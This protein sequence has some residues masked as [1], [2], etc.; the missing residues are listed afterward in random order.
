MHFSPVIIYNVLF[1]S[2]RQAQ[3]AVQEALP[4]LQKLGVLTQ[5]PE[6]YFAEMV[7]TDEHM[8]RVKGINR[9]LIILF[10]FIPQPKPFFSQK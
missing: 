10:N 9:A 4:R 3:L 7:K 8:Q 6:D 1:Y 5:R 2:Y